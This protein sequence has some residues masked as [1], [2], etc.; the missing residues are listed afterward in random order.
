[1]ANIKSAQTIVLTGKA[2]TEIDGL[3]C[4]LAYTDLLKLEGKNVV[5]V[6]PG[7]INRTVTEDI[8]KWPLHFETELPDLENKTLVV[9][10]MSDTKYISGFIPEEQITELFD[11]HSGFEDYWQKKLGD[12]AKIQKVGS[13]ATLIWEEYKKRHQDKNISPVNANLLYT[14]IISNNLNMFS[15]VT[16][17]RDRDALKELKGYTNLPSNWVEQYFRDQEK[18]VF[19]DPERTIKEDTKI[20]TLSNPPIKIAIAQLELWNSK[21]FIGKYLAEAKSNLINLGENLWFFTSPSISEGKNYLYTTS[22]ETKLLLD[23]ILKVK[24]DG[25]IAITDKL[26]LRKEIIKLLL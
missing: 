9:M 11:H 10:D 8:K 7:P 21:E 3:A 12:K 23:K 20:V 22:A 24:F 15:S 19:T 5:A 18:T 4:V 6:L 13:C 26:Y 17:Q 2:Y 1:M 14:A 16:D 25:D